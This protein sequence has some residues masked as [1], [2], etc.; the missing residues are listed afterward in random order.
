MI[1]FSDANRLLRYDPVTGLLVWRES[2]GG[3]LAGAVA[4]YTRRNKYVWVRVCGAMYGAHRLAWLLSCRQWAYIDHINGDPGDNRLCNLRPATHCQNMGNVK[5]HRDN[6][7]SFKGVFFDA[8]RRKYQ[9]QICVGGRKKYLGRFAT[10]QEAHAAYAAA[11][12]LHFGEF[13]RTA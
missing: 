8:H 11:A 5:R 2:R 1:S 12:K 13:A 9:A 6:A 7:S 4:G 10:P 3:V